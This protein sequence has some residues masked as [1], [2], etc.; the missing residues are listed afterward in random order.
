MS[1]SVSDEQRVIIDAPLE[2]HMK[3]SA[4]A[5][6]GK[7]FTLRNRVAR[8]I[9]EGVPSRKI[10]VVMFNKSAQ[11]DFAKKIRQLLG[12]EAAPQV[13][14]YHSLG[15]NICRTLAERGFL[16]D[17][18]LESRQFVARNMAKEA[19]RSVCEE[20]APNGFNPNKPSIQ[21]DFLDF[22]SLVKTSLQ[23]PGEAFAK[24]RID[25][26]NS[27]FIAAYAKF[28]EIRNNR[29]I[30][31]FSDLIYDPVWA[32]EHNEDARN[33]YA[34]RLSHI[35]IDEYQD[36][37]AI[38][39]RLICLLAGT[40]SRVTAVGDDAQTLYGF[41]GSRPDYL[42]SLFDEDFSDPVVHTLTTTF[43][44]GH[45]ISLASNALIRHNKD[46]VDK[47]CVSHATTPGT[48]IQ[49]RGQ[50]SK[51]NPVVET[52]SEWQAQ[53]RKL[54]E[55]AVLIRVFAIAPP[56]ELALLTKG[57]PYTLSGGTS[58]FDSIAITVMTDVLR[59]SAGIESE[60][61]AD[62]RKD[63]IQR[64]LSFPHPGVN[65]E[66]MA[67]IVSHVAGRPSDIDTAI[68]EKMADLPGFIASRLQKT[69]HAIAAVKELPSTSPSAIVGTY[70]RMTECFKR[71]EDMAARREDSDTQ[72]QTLLAFIEFCEHQS[73]S[74]PDL[75]KFIDDIRQGQS[76]SPSSGD[77]LLITSIHR[78]KGLE[79]PH[80]ILP[81]L[82]ESIFPYEREG[83]F[84]DIE[85][86]R[87]LFYVGITRA[88]EML[89]L[90]SPDDP[91]LR[92]A[93]SG[94]SAG[95]PAGIEG[96]PK[97]ASRF[98]YESDLRN[99]SAL[100]R[101][102]HHGKGY[103]DFITTNADRYNAYLQKAGSPYRIG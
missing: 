94:A 100:G 47:D 62:E 84:T 6:S 46:R 19:L 32:M 97:R 3:V 29:K 18:T 65:A 20:S 70:L 12:N 38:S 50:S 66:K 57:I 13:R 90:I 99:S 53:G 41:R 37:N 78:A 60:I 74:T 36:I 58:V 17:Y 10:L 22:I 76:S 98:L 96:D 75:L 71:I 92:Q 23:G 91:N 31:F 89:T 39:Q 35:I 61:P 27:P 69:A 52:V 87:R 9:A 67:E 68:C 15:F 79:W 51:S 7:S 28:E 55:V 102:I 72:T 80:V 1:L 16:P 11:Q 21:E 88:K 103:P 81:G 26:K 64:V 2:R 42:I 30:R 40:V 95:T 73:K 34:G 101:A 93:L 8:L 25:A 63:L 4:S 86:E 14:T 44:Y 85:S 77:T 56:I 54:R 33:V 43:R 59:L 49:W 45:A 83:R 48:A 5:G 82:A 24:Y